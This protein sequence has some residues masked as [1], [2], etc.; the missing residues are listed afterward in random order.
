MTAD[1]RTILNLIAIGRITPAE[2]ERLLTV[3]NHERETLVALIA[4]VLFAAL[5]ELHALQAAL[6]HAAG[7]ILP[8]V[9]AALHQAR[10]IITC[11][12]GGVQ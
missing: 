4:G 3:W 2:A 10:S 5:P 12:S 1:R 6:V 7:K 8:S 11:L 9:A